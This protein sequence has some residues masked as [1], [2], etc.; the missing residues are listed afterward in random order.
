[1]NG[2]RSSRGVALIT[3]M[4]VVALATT[5][6][7][8]MVSRQQLDIRRS[9]NQLQM[10]QAVL[11]LQGIEGWAG[12]ILRRDRTE[13]QH[14]S[15]DEDWALH[16]PPMPV[17]GGQLGGALE[18]M[19]GRFNLN[20]LLNADGEPDALA[21][22]RFR[23][24]LRTLQLSPDL[25]NAVVDWLDADME[26]SFPGGAE[27]ETY[28]NKNPPYRSANGLLASP[29]ELRL[30]EGV[31]AEVYTALA[32]HITALPT[33]T[34]IN[35]NTATAPVLSV[36]SDQLDLAQAEALV[37]A[38]EEAGEGFASVQ[39]FLAQD[40]LA[41]LDIEEQG[42]AVA[43]NYFMVHSAIEVGRIQ[44]IYASLLLRDS[45]GTTRLVTRAQGSF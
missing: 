29:S 11:Y 23:R 12:Q 5:A 34:A 28:L 43:S 6:A 40:S 42:L 33:R 31:D 1:M 14:D 20:N 38:R 41:G 37:A 30:I 15:L 3:A 16:L 44:L 8:A 35:L 13:S 4:L 45:A 25:A 17:E 22:E 9:G 39:E 24:L 27:D 18:D 19:Q 10:G 32:P 26:A 36:L 7:V 2:P 21:L